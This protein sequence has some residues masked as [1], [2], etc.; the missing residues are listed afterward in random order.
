M[1]QNGAR[2]T[3]PGTLPPAAVAVTEQQR[4]RD[5]VEIVISGGNQAGNYR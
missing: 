4:R 1:L 2:A 3:R 5:P